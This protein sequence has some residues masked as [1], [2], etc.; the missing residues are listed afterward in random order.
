MKKTSSKRFTYPS[1]T[2]L[3]WY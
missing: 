3:L 2:V 1:D